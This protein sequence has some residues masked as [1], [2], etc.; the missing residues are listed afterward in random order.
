MTKTI[1]VLGSTGSIGRNTLECVRRSRGRIRVS[2][3]AAGRNWELLA[4]QVEEFRPKL[5][6]VA[7]E[8]EARRL[9]EAVGSSCRVVW[10]KEG[11]LEVARH[12][13]AQM[14]VSAMVGAMGLIPT[15]EAI[16]AGK[17]VALANKETLVTAG[18][19][20]MSR[21]RERGVELLPVDSEHSAIFQCLQGLR[22]EEVERI[23]LTASGGPFLDRPAHELEGITVEEAVNHPNWSMGAKISIDSA[24]LMN[25]G[26]EVIEAHW[27]FSLPYDQISVVI[28]PQSIVHSMVECRDGSILAQM[29]VADMRGP[30]SLALHWPHRVDLDLP[31]LDLTRLPPLTFQPPD[32]RRFPCLRLAYQAGRAGG[33]VPAILNGANEVAV[34]A[35]M[36]GR[37]P[38]HR[39]PEVV[40][41]VL[42]RVDP[43]PLESLDS[44]LQADALA[45]L[46]AHAYIGL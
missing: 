31:R 23:I 11:C 8:E 13:E 18:E 12:P 41:A 5:A 39:I 45:R 30:I 27:L 43:P 16:E 1:A 7:G 10:G 22:R 35:F 38:F 34:E 17:D 46:Q 15:L 44:V 36:V 14:V 42:E 32:L 29:G 9:R 28:H 6:S 20:V 33:T 21:V 19:L 37:L 24:T 2:A 25:K 4:R 3:L 26:L 40:E